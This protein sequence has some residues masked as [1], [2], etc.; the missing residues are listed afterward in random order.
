MPR[1]TTRDLLFFTLVN[2]TLFALLAIVYRNSIDP[3]LSA[4]WWMGIG[5][6]WL[7]A[8]FILVLFFVSRNSPKKR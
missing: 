5:G 6:D 2:G 1:L 4:K 3:Q 7:I 8:N